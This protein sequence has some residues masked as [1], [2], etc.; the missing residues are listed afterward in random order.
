V[1]SIELTLNIEP[2]PKGRPRTSFIQGKAHTYTPEKTLVAQ[3][4]IVVLLK[5]YQDQCFPAHVPVKLT[6]TF[7]RHKSIWLPK[8]ERLPFRKPDLDNFLKLIMDS[9]NGILVADDAQITTIIM[10]K[11]WSPNNEGL[12][13]LRLEEDDEFTNYIEEEYAE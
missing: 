3:E 10:Q 6:C 13:Q 8:K 1:N 5:K 12:I 2:C 11:K 9:M 7:W 4:T